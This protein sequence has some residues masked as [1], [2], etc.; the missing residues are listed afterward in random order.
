[1]TAERATIFARA[2]GSG[3]AA[4]AVIRI[5]GPASGRI[6]DSLV[7]GRPQPRHASLRR[8]RAPRTGEVLDH[9][10]VLWFP[11]PASHT[12]EDGAELHLHAGAAVM[13]AVC[14]ALVRLGGRPA[15]PGEFTRRAFEH[16][17]LDLLEAEA[18]ADLVEAETQAQ[19]RQAMLQAD[20]AL[21]RLYGDWSDRLRRLLAHQ[22][23]LIDFPD[24]DLPPEVEAGLIDGVTALLSEMT[25]HLEEGRHAQLVRSGVFVAVVGPPN[26]GKSSLVNRLAGRDVAMVSEWA[27]TTRDAIEVRLVLGDVPVTLVDTAGLRETID[28]L[29]AEGVRRAQ[30]HAAEADLVLQL[31]AGKVP[32]AL[33]PG[34]LLVWNKIDL[35]PPPAGWLGVSARSGAGFATL[36]RRLR[37]AAGAL[38]AGGTGPPLT[39]ARHR[40]GVAEAVRQLEAALALDLVELRG[41]ALRLAMRALGR[42]TGIVGVEDLLDSVFGDFCIGK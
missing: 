23:A 30:R 5:S 1:M 15:E 32:E 8:L 10:L 4:I 17:K 41:E 42:L 18:I 6:L 39:R 16:G 25:L 40:A 31:A 19:R 29:E 33:P 24:E 7:G 22:E 9:G 2:T 12:G 38:T 21:S 37:D 13:E 34:A 36:E 28:P 27:G 20:G 35:A 26:V 11:G 14:D 3:R